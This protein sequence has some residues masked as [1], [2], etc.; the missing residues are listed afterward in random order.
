MKTSKRSYG[1]PMATRYDRARPGGSAGKTGDEAVPG[2]IAEIVLEGS[3][4]RW[5]CDWNGVRL[6]GDTKPFC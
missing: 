6:L 4:V 2:L 3:G 1:D 5:R